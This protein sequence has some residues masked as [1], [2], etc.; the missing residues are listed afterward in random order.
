MRAYQISF[1]KE[2]QNNYVDSEDNEF[3]KI[4]QSGAK[5]IKVQTLI[6]ILGLKV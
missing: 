2:I 4:V 3:E 6:T 1:R 5:V